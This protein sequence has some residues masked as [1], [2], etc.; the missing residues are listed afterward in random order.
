MLSDGC[1]SRVAKTRAVRDDCAAPGRRSGQHRA[2]ATQQ[3]VRNA[4]VHTSHQMTVDGTMQANRDWREE[5]QADMPCGEPRGSP[6]RIRPRPE[7][8]LFFTEFFFVTTF[9]YLQI[10]ALRRSCFEIFF[11][12]SQ[13][14]KL[15]DLRV[16]L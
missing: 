2:A 5:D 8:L 3:C 12:S 14:A 7:R 11:H 16:R 13:F 10:D 4:R 1:N 9:F 15:A 6:V